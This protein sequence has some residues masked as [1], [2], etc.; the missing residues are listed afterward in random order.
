MSNDQTHHASPEGLPQGY[1]FNP[2]WEIA[3]REL[4]RRRAAGEPV[5]LID[6]RTETERLLAKIEGS[7]HVPMQ[8]IS[9]H[10]DALRVHEAA[11]VVVHC[12]HGVRSLQVTQLLRKAGFDDV[13]SLAGGIHLWASDIDRTIAIY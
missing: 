7:I 12:H 11:V 10:I 5:V 6:C 8:S 1:P 4:Q 2:E 3:P 13:K 9:V